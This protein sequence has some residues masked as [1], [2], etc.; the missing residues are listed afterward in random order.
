MLRSVERVAASKR[1]SIVAARH[2]VLRN[3]MGGLGMAKILAEVV[4]GPDGMFKAV[5]TY[6]GS[7]IGEFPVASVAE[8]EA[9][10]VEE[11]RELAER[12]AAEA[13]DSD[14]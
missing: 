9:R 1:W 11:L 6:D 13:E 8:G 5:F 14:T 7:V 4:T 3:T 2:S 10:I 12:L